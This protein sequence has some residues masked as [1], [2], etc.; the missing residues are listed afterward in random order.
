MP[1]N[2]GSATTS[3]YEKST[4]GNAAAQQPLQPP[5]PPNGGLTAWIQVLGA[6]FLFFNSWGLVNSFGVFQTY[7]QDDLLK[8]SNASDISWIGTVQAFLLVALSVIVG[9]IF[10]RGYS[11]TLSNTHH[12]KRALA[13]GIT[14]SGGSLGSAIYPIV[15]ERLQRRIGI[16][17]ANTRVLGFISLATVIVS[18]V[19]M[20]T[21]LP[22]PKQAR[23]LLDLHAFQSIPYSFYSLG[24]FL[25]FAGLYIPIFYIIIWAQRHANVDS[26]LSF[27]LLAI[28]NASSIFGRIIPGLIADK[29]GSLETAIACT[30]VAGTLGYVAIVIKNLGVVS[31]PSAIVASL[32]PDMKLVGT[33]MGQSFFLAALGILIGSPIAGTIINVPENK[34]S[35]G[36]IFSATLIMAAGMSYCLAKAPKTKE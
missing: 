6:H 33:W 5:P 15:F 18:I 13:I 19:V 1:F 31:L 20:R 4:V 7:Y 35:D 10:D 36:F 21:R 28:L 30:L 12:P 22:P 16:P 26:T 34:F 25:S 14:A 32:T 9:P 2:D 11:R 17:W 23:A 3:D 29:Y 27:Y 24:L 8:S